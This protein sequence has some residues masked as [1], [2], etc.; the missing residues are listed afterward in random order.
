MDYIVTDAVTSPLELYS[1]YS[2]KLAFM[3][4]TFFIGD[5]WNMFPH[6][7]EKIILENKG[8]VKKDNIAVV[9]TVNVNSFLEKIPAADKVYCAKF[10]YVTLGGCH[11][12][13]IT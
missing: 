12:F 9:N 8:A 6:L 1:Q 3:R 10:C 4:D 7:S 13:F 11:F 5:H 2:E